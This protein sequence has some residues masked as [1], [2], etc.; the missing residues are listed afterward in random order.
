MYV[1]LI[2]FVGKKLNTALAKKI[3]QWEKKFQH[4]LKQF[5]GDFF[6]LAELEGD[7]GVPKGTRYG[8]GYRGHQCLLELDLRGSGNGFLTAIECL[9]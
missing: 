4:S 1:Q 7:T 9:T 6:D 8:E 5:I 3:L 2:Q